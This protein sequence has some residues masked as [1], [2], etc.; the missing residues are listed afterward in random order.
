MKIRKEVVYISDEEA[1]N[2][3]TLFIPES[4]MKNKALSN[5]AIA[6]YCVLQT[7][8]IPTQMPLQCITYQQIL[9]YLT[10]DTSQRRRINDCIKCGI[11]ELIDNHIVKKEK[12]FQK[13][14]VLDC[15]NLW[16]D[17]K[18]DKFTIITFD[19]VQNIF[20]VENVNNFLLLKYF[21]LLMGTISSK[22]TVYLNNSNFKNRVV[23]SFTIEY[24]AELSGISDRT[25]IEYNKILESIGLLY[26]YRQED[27]VIDKENN[28]KRLN[29]IYGR[30][31]DKEYINTYAFNQKKHFNSYQ[32]R[33]TNIEKANKKRRLAQ[34]YQ[35][36]IKGRS[37]KY[38]N[39]EIT[40]IYDYV[41]SEN[42]KYERMYEKDGCE[43]HLEKIRDI[44]IFKKYEF[45][46]EK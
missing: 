29:N 34:M 10:G 5:Y 15:S 13:H 14:L 20:E 4:V 26:V 25:V 36:L 31:R 12:E 16:I 44:E 46:K 35:Q 8:S 9:F 6:D 42:E 37:S 41:I 3:T 17:T 39:R 45:L 24:L 7:L 40:E 19:E 2:K 33:E 43:E 1:I 11:N 18:R 21:I 38:S 28:I 30:L 32:Y 27:F 23:G 22:I